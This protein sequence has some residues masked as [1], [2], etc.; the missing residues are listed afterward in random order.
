MNLP[1]EREIRRLILQAL[2]ERTTT[3]TLGTSTTSTTLT[4]ARIRYDSPILLQPTTANAAA[5]LDTT[6]VSETGRVNGSALI[7]HASTT[8]ADCTYRVFIG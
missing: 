8:L 3:V 1:N 5:A 7:T 2:G 6:Y 4:D